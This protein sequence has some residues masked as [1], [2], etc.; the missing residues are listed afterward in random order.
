MDTTSAYTALA[1][2]DTSRHAADQMAPLGQGDEA[3]P[4]EGSSEFG[5]QTGSLCK[6]Q[7]DSPESVSYLDSR[8]T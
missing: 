7:L 6:A 2:A 4:P 5:F 1:K 8:V 3:G